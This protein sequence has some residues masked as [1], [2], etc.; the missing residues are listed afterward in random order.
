MKCKKDVVAVAVGMAFAAVSMESA[1]ANPFGMT[2]LPNGY[3]VAQ[4][5]AGV[6]KTVER[7][8]AEGKCKE[9]KCAG[10]IGG[11]KAEHD[12]AKNAGHAAGVKKPEGNC[13]EGKCKQGKCA[14]Y[15]GGDRKE[16]KVEGKCAEGK[17]KEGKC[18][19]LKSNAHKEAPPVINWES[20]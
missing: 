3:M 8:C 9:G 5:D 14:G 19:G 1:L 7:K 11:A 2:V 20:K 16:A 18:I 6:E 15:R 4:N 10:N 12:G 13:A 17:C